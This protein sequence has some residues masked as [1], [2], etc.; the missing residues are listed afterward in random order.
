MS[1]SKTSK[2]SKK[3][4]RSSDTDTTGDEMQTYSPGIDDNKSI[5]L[6]FFQRF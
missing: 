2:T 5:I 4:S 1:K 3:Q 6:D